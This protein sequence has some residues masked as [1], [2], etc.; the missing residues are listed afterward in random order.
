MEKTLKIGIVQQANTAHVADN[1]AASRI[2]CAKWRSRVL[3]L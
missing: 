2:R 3:S 1:R